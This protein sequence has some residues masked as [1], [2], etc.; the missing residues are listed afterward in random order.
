MSRAFPRD[1]SECTKGDGYR[2]VPRGHY[3]ECVQRGDTRGQGGRREEANLNK[4]RWKKDEE[5]KRWSAR[6]RARVSPRGRSVLTRRTHVRDLRAR[7]QLPNC[8]SLFDAVRTHRRRRYAYHLLPSDNDTIRHSAIELTRRGRARTRAP[9]G[10]DTLRNFGAYR[11]V[12]RN[13]KSDSRTNC[14]SMIP[15]YF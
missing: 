4:R 11:H 8:C 5:F 15:P 13:P 2:D 9:I 14:K 10:A 1:D 6:A 3:R 7:R 12:L